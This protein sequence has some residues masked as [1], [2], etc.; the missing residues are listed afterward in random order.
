MPSFEQ[1]SRCPVASS[2]LVMRVQLSLQLMGHSTA[3]RNS[4]DGKKHHQHTR[5]RIS[6]S[7]NSIANDTASMMHHKVTLTHKG[8]THPG[9]WCRQPLH[10]TALY[11]SMMPV[12]ASFV[13]CVCTLCAG[14]GLSQQDLQYPPAAGHQPASRHLCVG[15]GG[16]KLSWR[17]ECCWVMRQAVRHQVA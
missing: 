7:S 6:E 8:N 4:S 16:V 1:H 5:S 10:F 11:Q 17:W 3:S 13:V 15:G 2:K 9:S 12:S 14:T